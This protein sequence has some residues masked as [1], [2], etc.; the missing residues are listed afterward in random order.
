MSNYDDVKCSVCEENAA[1]VRVSITDM[2]GVVHDI[3]VYCVKCLPTELVDC[4]LHGQ[5]N[6]T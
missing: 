5:N 6:P 3:L 2:E 4:I 1:E